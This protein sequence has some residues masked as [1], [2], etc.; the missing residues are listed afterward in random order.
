MYP[1]VTTPEGEYLQR[2]ILLS[3]VFGFDVSNEIIYIQCPG[4]FAEVVALVQK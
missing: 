2:Q 1:M 4:H 3:F